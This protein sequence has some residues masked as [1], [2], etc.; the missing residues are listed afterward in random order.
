MYIY[1][2]EITNNQAINRWWLSEVKTKAYESPKMT[3]EGD[4][5]YTESMVDIVYPVRENFIKEG[6][7]HT[8]EADDFNRYELSELYLPFGHYKVDKTG[9]YQR[10]QHIWLMG[11]S[12]LYVED[13]V[14]CQFEIATCGGLKIWL[15]DV[16]VESF[17]PYSRNI[18]SK[19]MV[20][21][22]LVKGLNKLQV[23]AD[24]LAER[25]AYFQFQMILKSHVRLMGL[26]EVD[27]EDADIHKVEDFLNSCHF[28]KD[29]WHEGEVSLQCTPGIL[30]DYFNLS[31]SLGKHLA[32]SHVSVH[33]R[34]K[35]INIGDVAELPGGIHEVVLTLHMSKASIV[36]RGLIG[37]NHGKDV[38]ALGVPS[39]IGQRKKIALEHICK[40]GDSDPVKLL[41]LIECEKSL[42]AESRK[43][44]EEAIRTVR[45][46]DDVSVLYIDVML[47]V[48]VRYAHVLS[49][50]LVE[51]MIDAIQNFRYWIDEEGNDV[52]WFFSESHSLHFHIAQYLTGTLLP[53][54]SY[55]ISGRNAL[56]QREL[57]KER[58]SAWF[59]HFFQYG[60]GDWNSI[61]HMPFNSL[62][63]FFLYELAEDEGIRQSAK[64]CLDFTFRQIV[65]HS[66]NGVLSGTYGRAYAR[67]IKGREL[68][69]PSMMSWVGY[70]SGCLNSTV[71]GTTLF[72]LSDY[73]PVDADFDV[74]TQEGQGIVIELN[75]GIKRT[76]MYTYR[77]KDYMMSS[78]QKFEPFTHGHQQHLMN[79][80][81]GDMSAQCF[82]N[83][84]GELNVEGI[85]R[86]GYWIGNDSMPLIRQYRNVML[87]KYRIPESAI[88]H[89]V[90]MFLP[91]GLMDELVVRH[92]SVFIRCGNA[93]LA[94][95]FNHPIRLL[96]IGPTTGKE[97]VCE[98]LWH[99]IYIKCS[100]G[101]MWARFD[102]FIEAVEQ[103]GISYF[104][105]G[106]VEV[107]DPEYGLIRLGK[108]GSLQVE[109]IPIRLVKGEE[110]LIERSMIG[111]V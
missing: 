76:P 61:T 9:F 54:V 51:S 17:V 45:D 46:K 10:P 48:I 31:I 41:A 102:E 62:G 42:T 13:D 30:E 27:T 79:V 33:P 101:F 89:F 84:P 74:A 67:E 96:E 24:D 70:G 38:D 93:Y 66:F 39:S 108:N 77:T 53:E 78:V 71:R 23:Y 19:K 57:G 15:N 3:L 82:I 36:W 100:S 34:T 32:K 6:M 88:A 20:T 1:K 7:I 58:L 72:C 55:T 4:I 12:F 16:W 2:Y 85:G 25:D 90:H 65:Y 91:P 28:E 14:K 63:F 11:E 80:A 56:E 111:K 49:E 44:L 99:D 107:E 83:H 68:S 43:L 8:I 52:M 50:D 59:E 98:G 110:I 60:Y 75:Q 64:Q 73:V 97:L 22:D 18:L 21:L 47:M 94:V 5:N 105:D 103:S 26:L 87:M 106:A 86:P 40:E 104:K 95:K 35:Q 29:M 81:L 69:E 37:I 92:Q 109:G